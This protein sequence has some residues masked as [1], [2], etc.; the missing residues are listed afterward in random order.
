VDFDPRVQVIA[1]QGLRHVEILT[2]TITHQQER[3][4]ELAR[5]ILQTIVDQLN[6]TLVRIGEI[7]GRLARW[8]RQSR[9]SRLPATV[10]GVGVMGA[11]AIA[12]TVADR[13]LFRPG[14]EFA[15]WLGMTPRQNSSGGRERLGRTRSAATTTSAACSPPARSRY[16]VTRNRPTRDG[17]WI[18]TLLA[19]KPTKVAAVGILGTQAVE[20][21]VN[22]L[23]AGAMPDAVMARYLIQDHRPSPPWPLNLLQPRISQVWFIPPERCRGPQEN[24][25]RIGG[26]EKG[27]FER[28]SARIE[29]AAQVCVR[30]KRR[31]ER[32]RKFVDSRWRKPD[33]NYWSRHGET[34]FGRAMWAPRTSSERR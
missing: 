30:N 23:F 13:S 22:E 24:S 4:P 34:P 32:N 11:S 20:V 2:K 14:R 25:G 19:R 9:V 27:E 8:H 28:N 10:P 5:S 6:G 1:P 26:F 3:L 29:V 18:P 33:S 16:C 15:A 17:E 7:E 31:L 21:F 12:A